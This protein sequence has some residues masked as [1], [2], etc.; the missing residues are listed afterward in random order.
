[1]KTDDEVYRLRRKIRA[2]ATAPIISKRADRAQ[3][4]Q[5]VVSHALCSRPISAQMRDISTVC[6]RHTLIDSACAVFV[7]GA[8]CKLDKFSGAI[9]RRST[10]DRIAARSSIARL[11]ARPVF[12]LD[13]HPRSAR[14]HR[15]IGFDDHQ[16]AQ[17]ARSLSLTS[18]SSTQRCR[19]IGA[20][21]PTLRHGRG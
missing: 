8:Q 11:N 21:R 7:H 3:R 9:V 17:R 12:K 15:G 13:P 18:A 2:N 14:G 10:V 5:Q 19:R 6:Q 1:L 16:I 20:L 4:S